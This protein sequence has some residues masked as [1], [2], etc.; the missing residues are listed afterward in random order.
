MYNNSKPDAATRE[1]FLDILRWA[2]GKKLAV[3]IH[4]QDG[5]S[6]NVLLDMYEQ[7]NRETP[8]TDLRWS[9]AH[10]DNAPAEVFPRM[11]VLGLG[12]TMQ[13]LAYLAGDRMVANE[14]AAV[15]PHMPPIM[16]ALRA[17]VVVGAGTDAHRVSSYNP[18][19]A[20]QWMVDGRTAGGQP[21]RGPDETPT[22]EEA[23]RMYTSRQRLV[24]LRR[25]QARDVGARQAGGLRRS[26]SRH[27]QRARRT[28]WVTRCRF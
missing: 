23:L 17:G 24:F 14:P 1:K 3:T 2:A 9:I 27:L 28:H 25:R 16:T 22:R 19:V 5:P 18:F 26:R 12:W 4:W 10:L 7:V 6:A 11:K 20:L 8:I 21:T 13:D 15:V